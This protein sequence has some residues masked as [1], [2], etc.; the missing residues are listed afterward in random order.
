MRA[1]LEIE[2]DILQVAKEMAALEGTTAGKVLSRLARQGLKPA[3]SN[4]QCNVRNGIRML[5]ARGELITVEHVRRIAEE[6]LA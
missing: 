4:L 6:S 5:P 2:D 1:T 3:P